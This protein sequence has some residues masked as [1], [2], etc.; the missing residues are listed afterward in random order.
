MF[1]KFIIEDYH[2]QVTF[3]PFGL[4]LAP[5]AFIKYVEVSAAYLCQRD[6]HMYPYLD[7]WLVQGLSKPQ[8]SWA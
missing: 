5:R 7:D 1:L 3:L 2:Y 4:S 8:A 6:V